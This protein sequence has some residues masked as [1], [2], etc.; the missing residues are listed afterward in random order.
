MRALQDLHANR[1]MVV[2]LGLTGD[3]ETIAALSNDAADEFSVDEDGSIWGHSIDE[4]EYE[5]NLT[6][7]TN[8]RYY[9]AR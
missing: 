5:D 4:T 8:I 2:D 1:M 9:A 3:I 7:K 6:F